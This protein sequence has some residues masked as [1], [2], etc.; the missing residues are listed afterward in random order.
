MT[1]SLM[2][3]GEIL[4]SEGK[5]EEA[6]QCFISVII[7]GYESKE[8]YNKLG[9]IAFHK[10]DIE[11]AIHY[12]TRALE[13]DPFY[14]SAVLN[15]FD[16][17]KSSTRY[18]LFIPVL[19]RFLEKYPDDE[20]VHQI[21][22]EVQE[23]VEEK[24]D[25]G[26]VFECETDPRDI[27]LSYFKK[28]REGQQIQIEKI[29]NLLK[30][31]NQEGYHI[32]KPYRNLILTGIPGSG[33]GLFSSILNSVEN[34]VC[35]DDTIDD[36]R[37][38]PQSYVYIRN[39]LL[40]SDSEQRKVV[41]EDVVVGLKQ[42]LVYLRLNA[43]QGLKQNEIETLINYGYRI[44]ALVREPV[45]T[46]ANWNNPESNHLL[47]AMVTD[48][49]LSPRWR[50]VVFSSNDKIERQAQV[51]QFYAGF[52]LNL[53][54]IIKFYTYEQITSNSDR[55]LKDVCDYF[56]LKYPGTMG[57]LE[58]MNIRSRYQNVEKIKQAVEKY[59][60]ARSGFGYLNAGDEGV[61]PPDLSE[62]DNILSRGEVDFQ[63]YA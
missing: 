40:E 47:E 27:P 14:K 1:V 4:F 19:K 10:E 23:H 2:K 32:N 7:N 58:N 35:A 42:N 8:A 63:K 45:Y 57:N 36:I 21:F 46:I 34:I 38:L 48:D 3:K 24:K 62:K 59:C 37:L 20:E 17:L 26:S 55:V 54:N 13:I 11:K 6:E 44:I 22:S 16:T 53:K 25:P 43:M 29:N 50:G 33:I 60:P 30:S 28:I 15:C 56:P 52:L 5:L 49:D 12:F 18:H 61:V 39:K 9:L 51:W 31:L 41:D